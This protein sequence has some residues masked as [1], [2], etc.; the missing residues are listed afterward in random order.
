MHGRR[1]FLNGF[2]KQPA[3]NNPSRTVDFEIIGRLSRAGSAPTLFERG[4]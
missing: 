2:T 1:N 3:G 4:G